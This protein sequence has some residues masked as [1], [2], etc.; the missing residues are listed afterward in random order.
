MAF[1]AKAVH[2]LRFDRSNVQHCSVEAFCGVGEGS[3]ESWSP[4]LDV[5][6]AR[7]LQ[8]SVTFCCSPWRIPTSCGLVL[9]NRL[10]GEFWGR[11]FFDLN[12]VFLAGITQSAVASRGPSGLAASVGLEAQALRACGPYGPRGFESHSRRQ[13]KRLDRKCEG[14]SG[15]LGSPPGGREKITVK[16]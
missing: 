15:V 16:E 12:A 8:K 1:H 11:I 6:V 9:G 7:M 14:I 5:R 4:S 13:H 3:F 2:G 10:L